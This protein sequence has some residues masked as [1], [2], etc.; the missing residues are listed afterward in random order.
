MIYKKNK[1][2][3]YFKY[4]IIQMKM[5]NIAMII[6]AIIGINYIVTAVMNFLGIGIQI[7]GSYLF[8]L[9]AILLFWGI[10]PAQENY[11]T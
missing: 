9:I 2:L 10:L 6:L 3:L 5:M 8:W 1:I 4:S 11:F 7:Y